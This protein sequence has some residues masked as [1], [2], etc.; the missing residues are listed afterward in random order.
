F[1]HALGAFHVARRVVARLKLEPAIARHVK[2]AALL[3]DIGHG[4]FSHAWEHVF[5]DSDHERWGA[6]IVSTPGELHDALIGLEPGLP[7]VLCSF[8]EK[9]YRPAFARKLVSSQLDVDRLD[10]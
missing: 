8:W 9:T 5:P 10:Y 4:P 3:H 7:A 1:G 6:R 2:L